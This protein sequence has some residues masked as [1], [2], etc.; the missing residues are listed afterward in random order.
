MTSHESYEIGSDSILGNFSKVAVA[1]DNA[2]CSKIGKYI[3][4]KKFIYASSSSVYGLNPTPWNETMNL[5]KFSSLYAA[6][7]V[8]N[9]AKWLG[10]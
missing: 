2:Y 10:S 7:K 3:K 5:K 4:V 1:V 6:T 9:E 8:S